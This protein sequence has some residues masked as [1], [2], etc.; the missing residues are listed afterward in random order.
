MND[1]QIGSL[2]RFGKKTFGR[3]CT[4]PFPDE[5]LWLSTFRTGFTGWTWLIHRCQVLHSLQLLR[6]RK[7]RKYLQTGDLSLWSKA[8]FALL[9]TGRLSGR[10][11]WQGGLVCKHRPA[12]CLHSNKSE[13]E[14]WVSL[15]KGAQYSAPELLR[16]TQ[17]WLKICA[18]VC[19]NARWSVLEPYFIFMLSFICVTRPMLWCSGIVC[20]RWNPNVPNQHWA[21]LRVWWLKLNSQCNQLYNTPVGAYEIL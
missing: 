11:G 5:S 16:R 19:I 13:R 21:D 7:M 14:T 17:E 15:P 6:R 20:S 12:L 18:S 4:G 3:S 8:N 1:S 2:F 10:P 9:N